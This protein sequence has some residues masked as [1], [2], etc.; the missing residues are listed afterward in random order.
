LFFL[1]RRRNQTIKPISA[2][3]I[4]GP[5]TA[6]AIQ[7][8]EPPPLLP[9]LLDEVSGAVSAV[10]TSCGIEKASKVLVEMILHARVQ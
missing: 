9:F 7:A 10:D 1:R 2:R 8:L 4:I 5:T 6:P 3:P